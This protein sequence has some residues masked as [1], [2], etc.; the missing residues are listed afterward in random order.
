MTMVATYGNQLIFFGLGRSWKI[1]TG[2]DPSPLEQYPMLD[3]GDG[4]TPT[5]C[6]MM[7]P[8]VNIQKAIEHGP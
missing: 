5:V 3:S 8:L 2:R 7:Y 6:I 1:D 4:S